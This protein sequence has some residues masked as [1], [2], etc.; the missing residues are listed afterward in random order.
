MPALVSACQTSSATDLILLHEHRGKPTSMVVSHFPHGPTAFFTLHNVQLRHDSDIFKGT[1][2]EVYPHLIFENFN[3]KLGKRIETVLK[4]LFPPGVKKDSSRVVSFIN[5]ND[6]ISVR[7]HMYA[8]VGKE[9]VLSEV[10]PR[11]DMRLYE[12]R[13]GTVEN[14][15]ADVEWH[16]S[17][18]TRTANKKDYL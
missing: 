1:V 10:G 15:D 5:K 9:V 8:K 7:H 3:T 11:F 17:S 16:L 2:S 12:L 4:H 18:F 14:K 6:Y 13:L